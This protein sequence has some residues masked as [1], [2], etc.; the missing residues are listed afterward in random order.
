MEDFWRKAVC[1]QRGQLGPLLE[2]KEGN[3][4]STWCGGKGILYSCPRFS[5]ELQIVKANCCWAFPH[6]LDTHVGNSKCPKLTSSPLSHQTATVLSLLRT[7][8]FF[9]PAGFQTRVLGFFNLL[10]G[11]CPISAP[12]LFHSPLC[13]HGS[14]LLSGRPVSSNL[15]QA[16]TSR[17]ASEPFRCPFHNRFDVTFYQVKYNPLSLGP[18]HIA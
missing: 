10:S 14:N 6:G 8:S 9:E 12:H 4:R 1:I 18:S 15:P 11:L 5:L 7:I 13:H 17:L 3:G 2:M 16:H